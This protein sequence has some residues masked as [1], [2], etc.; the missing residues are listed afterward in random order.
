MKIKSPLTYSKVL[1]FYLAT[2]GAI[3]AMT[4]LCLAKPDSNVLLALCGMATT[5]IVT[6]NRETTI[7]AMKSPDAP[8]VEG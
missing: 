7:Q 6:K 1:A 3:Y 2:L 5:L 8:K 4:S